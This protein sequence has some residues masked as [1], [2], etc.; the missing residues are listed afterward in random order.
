MDLRGNT[1]GSILQATDLRDRF[2][3]ARTQIGSVAFSDGCGALGAPRERWAEPADS[4][5]WNG[6]LDILIDEMTYSASEDFVLGLQGLEHVRV[7]GRPSGG[8]S[9][10]ARTIP[11]LPGIDLSI[12]TALTY[13]REMNPVEFYGIQPDAV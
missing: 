3:R 13:D 4:P 10:R 6:T 7:L 1:G 9:G 5:R 11:I 8:G 12:S 2:L